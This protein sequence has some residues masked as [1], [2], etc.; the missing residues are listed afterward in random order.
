MYSEFCE[1]WLLTIMNKTNI[2]NSVG[3]LESHIS[4]I[5]NGNKIAL[6]I[7]ITVQANIQGRRYQ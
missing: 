7:I 6:K 5:E 4:M 1:H 2:L 3:S